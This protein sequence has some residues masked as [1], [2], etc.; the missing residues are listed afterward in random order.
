MLIS[1]NSPVRINYFNSNIIQNENA[2]YCDVFKWTVLSWTSPEV[3]CLHMASAR[4]KMCT[5][6]VSNVIYHKF[7]HG[8]VSYW[9]NGKN[10][11]VM[12]KCYIPYLY[13][14]SNKT[15]FFSSP[16]N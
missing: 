11:N 6:N 10:A 13:L 2:R 9:V 3:K 14:F 7:S 1:D 4:C 8:T 5:L 16:L 12:L 15:G